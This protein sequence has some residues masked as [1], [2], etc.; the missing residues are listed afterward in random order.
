MLIKK[1]F[2]TPKKKKKQEGLS[3]LIY[4]QKS[5]ADSAC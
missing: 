5:S 1:I 3:S 2:S 4:K